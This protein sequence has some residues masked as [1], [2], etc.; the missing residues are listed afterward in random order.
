MSMGK[1]GK[2][3]NKQNRNGRE[4]QKQGN[5]RFVIESVAEPVF[6]TITESII[7]IFS[8]KSSI[9]F[10]ICLIIFFTIRLVYF[11]MKKKRD[12]KKY[13]KKSKKIRQEMKRT[14]ELT[15]DFDL[16]DNELYQKLIQKKRNLRTDYQRKCNQLEKNIRCAGLG[17]VLFICFTG[18]MIWFQYSDKEFM[19]SVTEEVIAEGSMEAGDC[20][21]DVLIKQLKSDDEIRNEDGNEE[22]EDISFI[23]DEPDRF[24]VIDES[25][26]YITDAKSDNVKE[27]VE[28]HMQAIYNKKRSD[29]LQDASPIEKNLINDITDIDNKFDYD[30][31]KAKEYKRKKHY[32]SWEDTVPNSNILEH[33]VIEPRKKFWEEEEFNYEL[34]FLLANDNQLFAN[35]YMAQNGNPETVIA[36]FA[37]TIIWTERALSFKNLPDEMKKKYLNYLKS[38]YKDISDFIENN[39]D[40]FENEEDRFQEMQEKSYAIY[41]SI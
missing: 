17:L 9:F 13:K 21:K 18:G 12:E 28:E 16:D 30:I 31:E 14:E 3:K 27:E 1:N 32:M 29:T 6:S 8:I 24:E 37:K 7:G 34:A 39:M 41:E 23:L 2:G 40:K 33:D 26:F 20:G 11:G 35:E 38:R 15:Q 19:T 25:V 36:Y 22:I 4:E 10:F 5:R